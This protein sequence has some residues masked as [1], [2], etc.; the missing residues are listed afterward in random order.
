MKL[1]SGAY[2]EWMHAWAP[3]ADAVMNGLS[4][5]RGTCCNP[6]RKFRFGV[7]CG[8]GKPP[9]FQNDAPESL[10]ITPRMVYLPNFS[11]N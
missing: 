8:R 6:W 10:D 7:C 3:H 1:A 5:V 11:R 2:L 4:A 9:D